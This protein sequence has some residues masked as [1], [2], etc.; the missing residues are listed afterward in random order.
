VKV[1]L[2]EKAIS[3]LVR[4]GRFIQQD[5]PARAI[6]FVN[7]I[8]QRCDTLAD[9]PHAFPLLPGRETS[10]I[11]RR[12]HRNDLIFYRVDEEAEQIDVLHVLNGAQD[13]DTI[14]FP[15]A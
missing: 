11:R 1:V 14:L 4:I 6:T 12:A 8:E 15:Q 7:E 5:N 2:T 13:Y 10:R 3:D 9:M